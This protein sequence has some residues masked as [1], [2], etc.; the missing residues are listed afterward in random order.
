[1]NYNSSRMNNKI[2]FKNKS[3][4]TGASAFL[5]S[6]QTNA[7]TTVPI[8]RGARD[9]FTK[10]FDFDVSTWLL[11]LLF[12]IMAITIFVLYSSLKAIMRHYGPAESLSE[13]NLPLHGKTIEDKEGVWTKFDRKFL[14]RAIPIEKEADIMLDHNYDGIRELDN[15][16]P[17]W[18]KWGFIV[19]IIFAVVYMISY[20]VS[21]TGKLQLQEYKDE[22]TQAQIAKEERIKISGENVNE[23]NVIALTD[24]N[25]LTEGKNIFDK[26][27]VACHLADGGGQVGP[28]LTDDFWIH[29]GGIKNIFA[30]ITNGVPAKGMISWKTQ[31]SP[32][33][34]QQVASFI[35]TL[36]GTIPLVAK[37]PQGDKWVEPMNQATDSTSTV[38]AGSSPKK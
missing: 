12:F 3:Y 10:I 14:T 23:E 30:T 8:N 19:T 29:G 36:H 32:K 21:G 4:L 38:V 9:G 37:E 35:L 33:Q 11:I 7:Q 1:M 17:P 15:S 22:L 2:N 16:L 5:L 13:K 27:C 28:N 26:N 18:W 20:H 6:L 31:L 34:M 24:V 25:R